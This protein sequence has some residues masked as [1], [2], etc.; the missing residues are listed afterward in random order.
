MVRGTRMSVVKVRRYFGKSK[1]VRVFK[2]PPRSTKLW[3]SKLL[4][5]MSLL[6]QLKHIPIGM[7]VTS[8]GATGAITTI[9][10]LAHAVR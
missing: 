6:L 2:G 7:L 3:Q 8:L 9:V 5:L 10:S 1:R 4:L